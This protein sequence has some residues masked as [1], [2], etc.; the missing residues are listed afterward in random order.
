[1]HTIRC[2]VVPAFAPPDQDGC[3]DKREY[4]DYQDK[5]RREEH[6]SGVVGVVVVAVVR[7]R[8]KRVPSIRRHGIPGDLD[9]AVWAFPTVSAETP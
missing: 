6:F 5:R 4:S 9:L 1:V 2:R 3:Q 7:R 8:R